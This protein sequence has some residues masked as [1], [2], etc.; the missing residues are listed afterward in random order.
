MNVTKSFD[1][2]VKRMKK[3]KRVH[4][5]KNLKLVQNIYMQNKVSELNVIG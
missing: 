2:K 5:S 1:E 3:Q 4:G